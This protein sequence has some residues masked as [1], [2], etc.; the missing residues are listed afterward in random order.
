VDEQ[1]H[2]VGVVGVDY[3]TSAV[4][5]VLNRSVAGHENYRWADV[6]ECHSG[7]E[8]NACLAVSHEK[9]QFAKTGSGQT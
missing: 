5:A 1:A 7:A 8:R 9:Q 3:H 2:L 6:V 4:T